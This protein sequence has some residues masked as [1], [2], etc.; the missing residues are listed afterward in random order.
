MKRFPWKK[1]TKKEDWLSGWPILILIQKAAMKSQHMN[2]SCL[3]AIMTFLSSLLGWKGNLIHYK[4]YFLLGCPKTLG[5]CH[6]NWK[7][8]IMGSLLAFPAILSARSLEWEDKELVERGEQV[9]G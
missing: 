9:R 4:T 6:Y 1:L 5:V 2:G 3:S 7:Q 8:T